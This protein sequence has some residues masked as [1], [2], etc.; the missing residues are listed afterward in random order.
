MH[1]LQRVFREECGCGGVAVGTELL[2]PRWATVGEALAAN[3]VVLSGGTGV[4]RRLVR[5]IAVLDWLSRR[6]P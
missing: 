2:T 3:R 5:E 4:M 1:A 6:T